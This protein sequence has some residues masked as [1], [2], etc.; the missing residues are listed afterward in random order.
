MSLIATRLA[1]TAR[2]S[3]LVA[4]EIAPAETLQRRLLVRLALCAG[5]LLA[6]AAAMA[7]IAAL[8]PA[9]PPATRSPFGAGFREA[10]PSATGLGAYILALQSSFYAALQGALGTFRSG[11][12]GPWPLIGIGF[13]YGVFH[14]A[15]PGHGKAV[16][17]G[18]IVSG[19]A[20]LRQGL[21]LST[22]AA[23]IQACVALL[24][25]GTVFVVLKQTAAT[26]SAT[27]LM[28]ER[29]SFIA[30]AA[31]GA[32]LLWRK[33]DVL[34]GSSDAAFC[35]C[36][37]ACLHGAFGSAAA[38]R[39]AGFR[40]MAGIALA[41]G[42]RPCA[43]AVILL[44]FAYSQ[45]MVAAG[46]AAVFAMA[47]G[48]ALTTGAIAA[49]TV[50]A[51]SVALRIFGGGT[52]RGSRAIAGAELLAAAFILVLGLTLLIGLWGGDRLV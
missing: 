21:A 29:A 33:S 45:G 52:G 42:L 48:T 49:L 46:M 30:M 16:I 18:Y 1:P 37:S 35:N 7:A 51:K 50:G 19:R 31:L 9:P 34:A 25:V 14:A 27:A 47:A 26:M 44:V 5:A 40:E 10:A 2:R 41:A 17:S 32:V 39:R 6:V 24:L 11:A 36:T 4:E 38:P 43:G 13:A 12:A 3:P 22:A 20:A 15:G 23:L 8:L 28:V